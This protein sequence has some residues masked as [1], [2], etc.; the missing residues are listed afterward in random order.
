MKK[1]KSNDKV[2]GISDAAVQAKT[3]KTWNEWF[4]ILDK[5]GAKKL[6]HPAIAVCL[7]RQPG[8]NP[9]WQQM[10]TVGYEQARGLRVKHETPQ[11][12]SVSRSKTL[13][14]PVSTLY[15]AWN[16]RKAR[17]RWL[18]DNGLTVRK[19][20]A[21]K[22]MRITWSDGKS[23]VEALFYAKGKQKSQVTVQHNKLANARQATQM[24]TYWGACLE[25]LQ[26]FLNA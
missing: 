12:Y 26:T 6:D 14:V 23:S 13:D 20:T 18:E 7:S 5:A 8:I 25:R 17:A 16:D 24:K 22:S 2:A 21:D 4:A 10:V 3:G 1:D 11:G 15:R 19:A 9:W